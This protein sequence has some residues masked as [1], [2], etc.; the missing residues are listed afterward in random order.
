MITIGILGRYLAPQYFRS[1]Q[2]RPKYLVN[3]RH[4]YADIEMPVRDSGTSQGVWRG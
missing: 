1:M 3:Q 2:E 4:A